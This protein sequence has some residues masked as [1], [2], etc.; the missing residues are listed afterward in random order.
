[1]V[2]LVHHLPQH[3]TLDCAVR[4]EVLSHLMLEVLAAELPAK[5][6]FT[7]GKFIRDT[8]FVWIGIHKHGRIDNK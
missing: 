3:A 4:V 7:G 5:H 8:L 1:M 6:N 2:P